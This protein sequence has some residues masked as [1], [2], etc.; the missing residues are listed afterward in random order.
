MCLTMISQQLVQTIQ[1]GLQKVLVLPI[2]LAKA[3]NWLNACGKHNNPIYTTKAILDAL[4]AALNS[5]QEIPVNLMSY[6]GHFINIQC[7]LGR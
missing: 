6:S 2:D 7:T 4:R 3:A 1:A 5:G